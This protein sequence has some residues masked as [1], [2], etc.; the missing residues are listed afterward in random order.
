VEKSKTPLG[1]P[2]M[3]VSTAVSLIFSSMALVACGGTAEETLDV[4]GTNNTICGL[5]CPTVDIPKTDDRTTPKP[6]TGNNQD[7]KE[8]TGDTTIVLETSVIKNVSDTSPA[9]SILTEN[10]SKTKAQIAIDPNIKNQKSWPQPVEMLKFRS[11]QSALDGSGKYTEYRALSRNSDSVAV[12]EELQVWHWKNSYATQY[13]DSSTEGEASHQAFSFGGNRTLA[14]KVPLTGKAVFEGRFGSTAKTWNWIDDNSKTAALSANNI[15]QV[16]G[17]STS[18]VDFASGSVNA[19]LK[20]QRWKGFMSRNNN[21]GWLTVVLDGSGVADGRDYTEYPKKFVDSDNPA[22]ELF[23]M[24]ENII[25][26]GTLKRDPKKGNSIAGRAKMDQTWVS[27]GNGSPFYGALFGKGG[28]EITGIF[29]VEAVAP[30]PTGPEFPINDDRR[31]FV[32]HSGVFNGT[33]K[34]GAGL[35]CN[36]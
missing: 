10:A 36:K 20:P 18:K 17:T 29:N 34:S 25:L 27:G 11:D 23:F 2:F 5:Q 24:R 16:N 12:D 19:T 13:R 28:E 4:A 21:S 30:Q 35:V 32:N 1:M 14:A 33:C 22:N 15:W 9:Y 31:G 7:I 26:K 8:D 6:N 3:R